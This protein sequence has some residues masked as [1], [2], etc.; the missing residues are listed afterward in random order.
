MRAS[1]ISPLNGIEPSPATCNHLKTLHAN[2]RIELRRL[3][4]LGKMRQVN[5]LAAG[6]TAACSLPTSQR[7]MGSAQAPSRLC[8]HEL[9]YTTVA[10]R[11]DVELTDHR[12]EALFVPGEILSLPM[13][14]FWTPI[15]FTTL[16]WWRCD[17]AA[18]PLLQHFS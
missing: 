7:I 3:E 14:E 4:K 11:K 16:V 10:S 6:R 9:R 2:A 8:G 18:L 5:K 1:T 17:L 15:P 13:P 12:L